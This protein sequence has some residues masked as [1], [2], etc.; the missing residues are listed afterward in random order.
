[1]STKKKSKAAAASSKPETITMEEQ[2]QEVIAFLKKYDGHMREVGRDNLKQALFGG[3][4]AILGVIL[5]TMVLGKKVG[6]WG[7]VIGA[8]LGSS[9]GYTFTSDYDDNVERL[10]NLG[11]SDKKRLV[12]SICKLL[13]EYGKLETTQ[14]LKVKGRME[15]VFFEVSKQ[16]NTRVKIW[17]ACKEVL[18][19]AKAEPSSKG[20]KQS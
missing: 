1:M 4:G 13:K 2:H 8:I 9:I 15:H 18:K 16:S 19:D 6:P 14:E 7:G 3:L 5:L 20:S 17:E 12:D 10:A 11:T